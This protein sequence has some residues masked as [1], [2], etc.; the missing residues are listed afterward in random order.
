[1]GV[2]PAPAEEAEPVKTPFTR[3]ILHLLGSEEILARFLRFLRIVI[4]SAGHT[5]KIRQPV[6]LRQGNEVVP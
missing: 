3:Q 2:K 5:G 1:M 4:A 6:S